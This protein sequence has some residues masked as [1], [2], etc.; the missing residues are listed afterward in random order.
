MSESMQPPRPPKEETKPVSFRLPLR[1][2]DAW[3]D[4]AKASNLTMSNWLR[5]QI[6]EVAIEAEQTK[7]KRRRGQPE[8]H[9]LYQRCD[10]AL[11][12]EIARIGSNLNQLSRQI[13]T[14]VGGRQ[15]DVIQFLTVFHQIRDEL[16]H[17]Q[18]SHTTTPAVD[19]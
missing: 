15:I 6:K 18:R 9:I 8:I 5:A 4:L 14:A 2:F 12:R 3:Q 16:A 19:D 7:I 1:I 10:P 11:I 13:N 17:L